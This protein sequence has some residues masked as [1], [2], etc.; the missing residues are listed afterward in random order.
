MDE[1]EEDV[2]LQAPES[3]KEIIFRQTKYSFFRTYYTLINFTF[4]SRLLYIILLII[5]FIQIGTLTIFHVSNNDFLSD[6]IDNSFPAQYKPI[7]SFIKN[8]EFRYNAFLKQSKEYYIAM[9]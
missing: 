7:F 9:L 4:T 3:T 5:E 2:N 8:I 6:N 1:K